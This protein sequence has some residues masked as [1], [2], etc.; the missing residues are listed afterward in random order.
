VDLFND[1]K[2]ELIADSVN[3]FFDAYLRDP[4]KPGL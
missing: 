3:E 2:P 1:S 4:R